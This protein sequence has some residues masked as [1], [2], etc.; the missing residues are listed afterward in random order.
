M[1]KTIDDNYPEIS[2]R[3]L[4]WYDHNRRNLPWRALP[5]EKSNPYYVLLSEI[6]LQQTIVA[7]VIPYFLKFIKKWPTINHLAQ[8]NFSAISNEWSGLGYYRRAKNLHETAKIISVKYNGCIPDNTSELLTFP[9]IGNYT[10]AAITAI[11]F[12]SDENVV[13]G[14]IERIF[15]RLYRIENPLELSKDRIKKLAAKHVPNKRNGDYA[16]ALMDLGSK[17]CISKTPRCKQCPLIFACQVAEKEEASEY[18]K[19]LPKKIKNTRY[20]LFF[21]LFDDQ[22]S[23]L[24]TTNKDKGLLSNMDMIPSKGWYESENRLESSPL[25]ISKKLSFLGLEWR[26]LPNEVIHTFTHFKLHCT[27]AYYKIKDKRGIEQLNLDFPF[28]FVKQID[29]KHLAL[30]T[31]MK[32]IIKSV[33]DSKT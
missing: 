23:L 31:L 5:G 12:N 6:M 1:N 15:S 27:I 3:L 17:V 8:A 29:F 19:R 33:N 24:F 16:Q 20:G 32:K 21:C 18:P 11:A 30:P 28:R 10:A 26:V 22:N 9:G 14:N 13:D 25:N 4:K 2:V 7:T